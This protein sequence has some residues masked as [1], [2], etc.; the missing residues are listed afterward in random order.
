MIKYNFFN[1]FTFLKWSQM[2]REAICSICF[3]PIFG[4]MSF[5]NIAKIILFTGNQCLIEVE[6]CDVWLVKK[7]KKNRYFVHI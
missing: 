6:Y 2:T 1:N 3:F 5:Y 4:F 7:A